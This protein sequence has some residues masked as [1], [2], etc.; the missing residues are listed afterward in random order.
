M[1]RKRSRQDLGARPP[2]GRKHDARADAG[3]ERLPAW[4]LAAL[5]LASVALLGVALRLTSPRARAAASLGRG[6]PRCFALD[7]EERVKLLGAANR[8]VNR[9]IATSSPGAAG[10]LFNLGLLALH[11]F[12]QLE[13]TTM[14]QACLRADPGAAMCHWGLAHAQG[15]MPN[16]VPGRL[17]Q[18]FPAYTAAHATDAHAHMQAALR[19]SDAALGSSSLDAALVRRDRRIIDAAAARFGGGAAALRD[20]SWRAREAAWAERMAAIGEEDQDADAYALGAEAVMN[21]LP[22]DY[23]GASGALRPAAAEAERLLRAALALRPGHGHALHLHIHIA[24]AGS[25]L[26][27][28]GRE[29]DWAGRAFGSADALARQAGALADGHLL[30]MPS[31]IYVRLGR[32]ADA[33]AVNR[34]AAEHDVTRGAQCRVPYL[35][36]HNLA[37]LIYAASM[38]G[39]FHTAEAFAR[40]VRTLRTRVPD[41]WMAAGSE[42]VSLP[43]LYIRYGEWAKLASLPPPPADARGVTALGGPQYAAVVRRAGATL[44]AAARMQAAAEQVLGVGD[45]TAFDLARKSLAL[46]EAEAARELAALRAAVAAVPAE[47]VTLPGQPPGMYASGYRAL[48]AIMLRL[49]E[50]RLRLAANN[51]AG[52]LEALDEAVAEEAALGYMEPPRV[53]QPPRQCLAWVL[54]RAGRLDEAAATYEADLAAHPGNGWSLLGLQ[55]VAA[56]RGRGAAQAGD[57]FAAAWAHAEVDIASSCPALARPHPG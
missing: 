40:G 16:K 26:A 39:M 55:Q 27:A 5:L 18:T 43:T 38:A 30:H 25:P 6:P 17:G 11:S 22:W 33:V 21:G 14:F 50:A 23:Y 41:T 7:D 44:V 49:A 15:P 13:A 52:A 47:P 4:Q 31:H 35:P 32:Y 20:G 36:E 42:W 46:R 51:M 28:P 1:V 34:A 45:V 10:V 37:V 9:S 29:A 3:R 24:E 2:R 8:A 56:A 57:A 54:L 19:A 53:H 12:N 48:A